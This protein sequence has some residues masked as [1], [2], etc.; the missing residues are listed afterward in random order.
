MLFRRDVSREDRVHDPAKIDAEILDLRAVGHRD[1]G[2]DPNQKLVQQ[3]PAGPE[4]HEL[5]AI[6][7]GQ[8]GELFRPVGVGRDVF[9]TID[10]RKVANLPR[11][12]RCDPGVPVIELGRAAQRRGHFGRRRPA[13]V[14]DGVIAA[15]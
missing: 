11:D 6:E 7:T 15:A 4:G 9:R 8:I 5:A 3:E 10:G 13:G 2:R 12:T 1:V 14:G